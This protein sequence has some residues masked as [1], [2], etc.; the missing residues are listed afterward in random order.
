MLL[1]QN[2]NS[3]VMNF[4]KNESHFTNF[5]TFTN[6]EKFSVEKLVLSN[7]KNDQR[8]NVMYYK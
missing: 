5:G 8:S 1:L 3:A 2:E 4:F 7:F 6:F